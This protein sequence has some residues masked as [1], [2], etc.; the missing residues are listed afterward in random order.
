MDSN[1]RRETELGA[2][3][4]TPRGDTRGHWRRASRVPGSLVPRHSP[5]GK[6][7]LGTDHRLPL[8]GLARIDSRSPKFSSQMPGVTRGGHL[9]F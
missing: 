9:P 2:P 8:L 1:F 4:S 7:D 5:W 3:G 6:P